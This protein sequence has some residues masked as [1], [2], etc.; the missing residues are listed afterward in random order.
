[1]YA[2]TC[3]VKGNSDPNVMKGIVAGFA[4]K[5]KEEEE[6]EKEVQSKEDS[7]CDGNCD[8]YKSLCTMNGLLVLTTKDN[9]ILDLIDKIPDPKERRAQLEAYL[10]VNKDMPEASKESLLKKFT[11]RKGLRVLDRSYAHRDCEQVARSTGQQGWWRDEL[12]ELWRCDLAEDEALLQDRGT[13]PRNIFRRS[14]TP[15]KG[16]REPRHGCH[17]GHRHWLA[18]HAQVPAGHRCCRGTEEA[19]RGHGGAGRPA[20]AELGRRARRGS[21]RPRPTAATCRPIPGQGLQ[22]QPGEAG[23]PAR[24][25]QPRSA[26]GGAVA[27]RG[28]GVAGPRAGGPGPPTPLGGTAAQL[29]RQPLPPR[30]G[31]ACRPTGLQ[32]AA[33]F[34]KAGNAPPAWRGCRPTTDG[35]TCRPAP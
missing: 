8:Y 30:P 26:P 13:G 20:T 15:Q 27:P 6:S 16:P 3:K 33:F 32:L 5:L 24:A 7:N 23:R 34:P 25:G 10:E 14:G 9:L 12:E 28:R 1:M 18:G 19:G 11:N 2:T 29:G 31:G 35:G 17:T 21:S 4:G 22:A